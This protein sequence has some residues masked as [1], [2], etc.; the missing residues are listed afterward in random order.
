MLGRSVSDPF[1]VE[2][3]DRMAA[4]LDLL[5]AVTSMARVKTTRV[6]RARSRGGTAFTGYE[7]HLGTTHLDG[8]CE[9]FARFDDGTAEGACRDNVIGTYLHGAL[10]NPDVCAELFGIPARAFALKSEDYARLAVWF[11]QHGRG[12]KRM[13]LT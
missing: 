6:R 12:L 9:P 7:I 4:G 2:S 11:A 5:P 13:G 1:G 8:A 3:H 10:E